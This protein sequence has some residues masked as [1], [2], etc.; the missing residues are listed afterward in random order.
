MQASGRPAEG[1][2]VIGDDVPVAP[3][4][5]VLVEDDP[6]DVLIT[7]E[8]FAEHKLR[9]RLTVLSDG[10]QAIAFLRRTGRYADALPPDVIL[11]DLN[12]P[13]LDGHAVLKVIRADPE[14]RPIPVVILTNSDIDEHLLRVPV[15][16]YMR[17]P[18]DFAKLVDLVQH[19]DALY[20]QI[21]KIEPVACP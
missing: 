7:R 8:A 17:K 3:I 16:A 11:L 5:I 1:K 20:L 13:V 2:I 12:L 10:A 4:H 19:T 6:G 9:N 14:L 15:D 21:E 18:V